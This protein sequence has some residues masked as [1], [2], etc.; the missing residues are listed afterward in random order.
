MGKGIKWPGREFDLST[1]TFNDDKNKWICMYTNR[2]SLHVVHKDT[3]HDFYHFR[4][5]FT[6]ILQEPDAFVIR[7]IR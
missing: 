7:V 5:V 1:L 3:F 2:D 4:L 6:D